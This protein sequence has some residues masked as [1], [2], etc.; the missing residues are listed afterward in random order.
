MMSGGTVMRWTGRL[1]QVKQSILLIYGY[2]SKIWG[3]A[4]SENSP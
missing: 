4:V 2:H 3:A 1:A